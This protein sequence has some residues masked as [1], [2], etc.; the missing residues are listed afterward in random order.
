MSTFLALVQSGV[1]SE[2][3]AVVDHPLNPSP[4]MIMATC[5]IDQIK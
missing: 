4:E 3:D 5:E 2:D 1:G